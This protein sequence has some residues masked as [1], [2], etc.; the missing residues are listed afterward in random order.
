LNL[1]TDE[2]W[3]DAAEQAWQAWRAR[4]HLTQPAQAVDVGAIRE[5]LVRIAAE[6]HKSALTLGQ[7]GLRGQCIQTA[8]ELHELTRHPAS[9]T[10]DKEG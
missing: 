10:P 7:E 6:N 2:Y 4:A 3:D 1:A 9:T 5:A 8:K